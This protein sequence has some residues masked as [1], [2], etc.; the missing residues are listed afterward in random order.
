[1]SDILNKVISSQEE[2]LKSNTSVLAIIDS[3]LSLLRA[4]EAEIL[5]L[6]FG[7]LDSK[8]YTLENIGKRMN[9]TRERV[10]QL[11]KIA[12][13][14]IR[15]HKTF[16]N[17]INP[18]KN[19]IINILHEHGGLVRK[20]K[21]AQVLAFNQ[22]I[23]N[24]K[25]AL[26][27]IVDNFIDEIKIIDHEIFDAGWY[28]HDDYLNLAVEVIQELKRLIEERN[29]LIKEDDLFDE[30]KKTNYYMDNQERFGKV[31]EKNKGDLKKV[32]GA[33]LD[34][35]SEL[36]KTPFMQWGKKDWR[37]VSPKRIND[38]IYLIL[39][40]Y[41]KPMHFRD[42]AD[43]I[44]QAVFDKKV[45]H[46]ATIHNDLI[47]DERF[48]LIGRGVYAL[49]EWGYK[50]GVVSDVIEEI[51]KKSTEP[52]SKED[53]IQEVLKQRDVKPNTVILALNKDE[54]FIK[55]DDNKYNLR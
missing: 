22:E 31:L 4:R 47:S 14:N 42:I 5:R 30:F 51:L 48:V 6:R 29:K 8:K 25:Q 26:E 44:N 11:E 1:M 10:R 16:G 18:V 55:T 34:L 52:L 43:K 41:G 28:I 7:L 33:Y 36:G 13:E 54:K 12:K 53:I 20:E 21:I 2:A 35:S 38:K 37:S 46:P 39:D 9:L 32:L 50:T 45:A 24:Y 49:N 19:Q 40:W 23:K 17:I 27:F 3:L 15:N